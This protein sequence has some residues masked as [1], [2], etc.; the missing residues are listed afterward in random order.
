MACVEI[1]SPPQPQLGPSSKNYFRKF[2]RFQ[3]KKAKKALKNTLKSRSKNLRA[4]IKFVS[5][6]HVSAARA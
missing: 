3:Q 5:Q 1:Q 4:R 2:R 6:V